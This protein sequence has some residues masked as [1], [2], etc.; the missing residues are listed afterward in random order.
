V[1]SGNYSETTT[2]DLNEDVV[3]EDAIAEHYDYDSDS[4]LGDEGDFEAA[5]A[6]SRGDKTQDTTRYFGVFPVAFGFLHPKL[7]TSEDD[8]PTDREER[9]EGRVIKVQDVAYITYVRSK[10]TMNR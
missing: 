6:S 9:M 4:D 8:A 5:E 1:F 3:E 7:N 2:K 10:S